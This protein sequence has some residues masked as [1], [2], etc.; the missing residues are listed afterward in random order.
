MNHRIISA[1]LGT[2]L[3]ASLVGQ[4]TRLVPSQYPTI[5]SGINASINGDTVLVA[6]GTYS[7]AI[8]YTGKTITI[9]SSG[10]SAVTTIS[11]NAGSAAVTF[12]GGEGSTAVLQGFRITG[13]GPGIYCHNASPQILNCLVTNNFAPFGANQAAGGLKCL[14]D[15]GTGSPTITN[16]TFSNNAGF[17]GGAMSFET[18]GSGASSPTVFGCTISNN[19]SQ[20]EMGGGGQNGGGIYLSGAVQLSVLN[21]VIADNVAGYPYGHGGAIYH[22]GLSLLVQNCRITRNHAMVTAGITGNSVSLVGTLVAAN[23]SFGL[24]Q[25]ATLDLGPGSSVNLCTITANTTDGFAG[26]IV[27]QALPI[28]ISNSIV[29]GNDNIDMYAF[30]GAAFSASY[31]DIGVSNFSVSGTNFSADPLF[32]DAAGGDYHLSTGSPCRNTGTPSAVGLP[33]TDI[34]GA[35]RFVGSAVDMGVDEVPTLSFPGTPD[36]LDL[37][38]NVNGTGDPLASVRS[39]NAGSLLSVRI[40]SSSGSL[41]GGLPL[42]AARLYFTGNPFAVPG[43]GI[44]MDGQSVVFYGS[45][46]A[47]PFGFPGLPADGLQF[48]FTVPAGLTGQTVRM[49]GLVTSVNAS[50]GLYATSN[51][52]EV[53]F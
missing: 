30:T 23:H 15:A 22:S 34:D 35:P 5:Q 18:T 43:G 52:T 39:A 16:C 24:N 38:A 12:Q 29:W 11:G 13:G 9:N 17:R 44:W 32:V 19:I 20:Q 6:P 28:S 50:N 25:G 51:A 27:S 36:A 42:L 37:Y 8:N 31:S 2:L 14:I 21:T 53:T 46:S 47:P 49:Q 7:G 40:K 41:V 4:T 33:T 1:V 45:L 10:G 26:G 3:T 48:D